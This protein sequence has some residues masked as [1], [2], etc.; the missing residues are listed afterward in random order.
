MATNF[1]T[2]TIQ[3]KICGLRQLIGNTPLL[4][5]RYTYKGRENV[6]YAKAE[7]FNMSG[8]IKDR[9]ALYMLEQAYLSGEIKEG[10]TIV[11]ATSGNTGISFCAVGRALGHPVKIF[12]PEWMSKERMALIRSFGAEIELVSHEQGGFIGSIAMAEQS[13]QDNANTFLPRQFDNHHNT[14][15]HYY[16]TASE[17]WEQCAKLGVK[18]DAFVA[19]VGTGGTVMG[20][21]RYLKEKDP[22]IRVCP[23]EPANSP[24]LN[25]GYKIGNHRIQG[26]SDE[27]IPSIVKLQELDEIV[28]VDDGDAI[29]MAQ[30]L[31]KELG[32][33]V[34]ISSGA[35][36]LGAVKIQA[37]YPNHSV[38]TI[39]ADDN[40][41][42]L[43]TD[44]V[45]CQPDNPLFLTNHLSLNAVESVR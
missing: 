31:A 17:I 38:V 3:N 45:C 28:S 18:P 44:Y 23:L 36:F 27:F 1:M 33:G 12:M 2:Q 5:I 37:K 9:I 26:I 15:S 39:F 34:G 6:I 43:T 42:Y 25:T 11:E 14:N 8:S 7:Y 32:V 30:M 22:H 13:A 20:I 41:K 4:A 29:R 40:K 16:S 10:D 35:N 21:G 19:G 24:T